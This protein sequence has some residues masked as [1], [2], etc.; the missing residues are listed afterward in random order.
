[1]RTHSVCAA[2]VEILPS[3]ILLS[4]A[5]EHPVPID[6]PSP[7]AQSTVTVADGLLL[8]QGTDGA[9][10][11]TLWTE[12]EVVHV[13]VGDVQRQFDLVALHGVQIRVGGGDDVVDCRGLTLPTRIW[14]GAGND[15]LIG[16]S[17]GDEIHG[18]PGR[19]TIHGMAGNDTVFGGEGADWIGLGSGDDLAYGGGG[20]DTIRGRRGNDTLW[21]LDGSD[22]LIGGEGNDL[23]YGNAGDDL[24]ID[25]EGKDTLRGGRGD[26]GFKTWDGGE[27]GVFYGGAGTDNIMCYPWPMSKPYPLS[28]SI[29]IV[30]QIQDH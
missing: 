23:L 21:G 17:A 30:E 24:L 26:D 18:A 25:G 3:R 9:D 14:G 1:M 5:S 8:V 6:F 20:N 28:I 4:V 15:S 16:G 10:N 7:P 27:T 12:A 2:Q 13:R 22:T 29:E 19:D 11:V